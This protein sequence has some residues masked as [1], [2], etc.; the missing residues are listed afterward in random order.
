[1][2]NL[3]SVKIIRRPPPAAVQ[4]RAIQQEIIKQLKPVGQ[5]HVNER[6]KI[7]SDFETDIQF[8]YRVSAT[9]KQITLTVTV[10]NSEEQLEDS[11]WT[12]GELWRALDKKGT[13]AHTITGK[14]GKLSFQWGGPGSY[15]PKTRPIGRSGGPGRVNRG[16]KVAR[17]SVNHPGFPPR[18]F[19]R[20]INKKL[21]S[22]FEKAIDRGVRLGGK[23]RR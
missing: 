12:V 9:Q 7:V 4:F 16:E 23:K 15:Q 19:S 18:H 21:R 11:K 8:G 6:D 13:A 20:V 22:L 17:K 3:G 1:M 10:E 14:K 5:E 2:G